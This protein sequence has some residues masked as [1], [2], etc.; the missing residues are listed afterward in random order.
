MQQSHSLDDGK[1]W[2]P[3]QSNGLT[4]VMPFTTIEPIE[5]GKALLAMTNIRRPGDQKEKRSNVIAQSR[6]TDGGFTW[7]PLQIVHDLPGLKPCEPEIVRSRAGAQL[8]CLMRENARHESLYSL[9]TDDG[10]SW[11][12]PKL[13]PPGLFGDLHAAKFTADGRLVVCFRDTG[14]NSPTKDHFVA[15]VGRYEDIL[16]G[17]PGQYRIKL[18]HSHDG[19]DCGYSGVERLA[20]DTLVATTYIKYRP[21]PAKQSIVSVRFKLSEIDELAKS[22]A[23]R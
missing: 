21:G 11:S 23:A 20:D 7:S 13:L 1:T 15:W 16:S 6:S 17:A 3:M 14:E 12:A 4:A 5:N 10:R 18:L 9:S 19:K 22:G 8:L 2:T